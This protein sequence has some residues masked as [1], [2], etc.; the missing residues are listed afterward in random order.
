MGIKFLL[1]MQIVYIHRGVTQHCPTSV[2][3]ENTVK[4]QRTQRVGWHASV[5]ALGT[6]GRKL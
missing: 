5:P 2:L 4:R 6:G 1:Y 3:A